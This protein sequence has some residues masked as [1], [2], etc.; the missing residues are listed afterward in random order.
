MKAKTPA[1]EHSDYPIFD[2]CFGDAAKAKIP[3]I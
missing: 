1:I 3:M 2:S